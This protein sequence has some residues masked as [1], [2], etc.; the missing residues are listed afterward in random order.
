MKC[1]RCGTRKALWTAIEDPEQDGDE[2]LALCLCTK[3]LEASE[4]DGPWTA[5]YRIDDRRPAA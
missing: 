5:V 4:R 2:T 3:C 1:E